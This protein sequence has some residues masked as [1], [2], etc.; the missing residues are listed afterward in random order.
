MNMN[1][2]ME[3]EIIVANKNYMKKRYQMYVDAVSDLAEK[4]ETREK[5]A[6]RK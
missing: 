1:E 4:A 6:D 2:V 5:K 3:K